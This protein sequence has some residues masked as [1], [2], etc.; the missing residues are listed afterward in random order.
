MT[1]TTAAGA[2]PRGDDAPIRF[3]D[4]QAMLLESA[5]AFAREQSTIA[6]V[7]RRMELPDGFE[8]AL[9]QRIVELGWPAIAVPERFGGAG[10]TLAEV[11]TV[12]EPMGRHLMAGPFAS[13]QQFVQVLLASGDEALQAAWLPRVCDGAIGTVAAFEADGDWDLTRIDARAT[14]RDDVLELSGEKTLVCDAAV[15]DAVFAS[16]ALDGEPALVLLARDQ[17]D[18]KRLRRDTVIDETRRVYDLALQGLSVP[19]SSAITGAPAR[20]ALAMIRACA[21]LIASAEAAGGIAGVLDVVVPYLNTRSAFGRKIGGYQALKHGSA[22]MLVC[23]ERSRSHVAHAATVLGAGGDAEVAL[24]MAKVEA[25]DGLMFAGDRAVQF[26]GGFGFTWDCDAH[27][28]LRRGLWLQ[29]LHGDSAHH[30]AWL[31]DWL[32]GAVSGG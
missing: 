7:R 26:H 15:A 4:E 8:P 28:Y 25:C 13:T 3:G 11:A 19:L 30:R 27:L 20:A 32:L 22:E 12:A 14:R 9:W 21:Q 6:D 18:D 5:A 2:A 1:N 10:L 17:L 24:R 16:V 23:L 29:S 31:A